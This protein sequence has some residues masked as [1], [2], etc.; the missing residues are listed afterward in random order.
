[1][2]TKYIAKQLRKIAEEINR[3]STS[4]EKHFSQD[5][6]HDAFNKR[7]QGKFHIDINQ[8]KRKMVEI[9]DKEKRIE[10]LTKSFNKDMLA[11]IYSEVRGKP[12]NKKLPKE[13]IAHLIYMDLFGFKKG[14]RVVRRYHKL[15][16]E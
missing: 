11:T 2:D 7:H 8:I 13:R 4:L 15:S 1:M 3:I 10:Y 16:E 6:H 5:E 14:H 12:T 9:K